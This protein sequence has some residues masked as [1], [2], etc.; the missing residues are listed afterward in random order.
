MIGSLIAVRAPSVRRQI[1]V[2]RVQAERAVTR[3]RHH[4]DLGR[5][6]E[7]GRLRGGIDH[8]PLHPGDVVVPDDAPR[9]R[10]ELP[11][12]GEA[13][14]H[15]DARADGGAHDHLGRLHVGQAQG[16]VE[17]GVAH[18][19]AD[20]VAGRGEAVRGVELHRA[21]ARFGTPSRRM[22]S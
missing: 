7:R 2:G 22:R 20:F 15:V 12:V 5:D 10:V 11:G 3:H 9:D 8:E 1:A 4:A 17:L 21:V 19:V 14:V 18:R 6:G 16:R 13:H